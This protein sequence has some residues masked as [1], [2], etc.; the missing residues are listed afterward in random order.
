MWSGFS[1]ERH[2]LRFWRM[3]LHQSRY[4]I[5][6]NLQ[7]K[8]FIISELFVFNSAFIIGIGNWV[9]ACH[10]AKS[11]SWCQ[12]PREN[13]TSQ[14][15]C[16]WQPYLARQEGQNKEQLAKARRVG[17]SSPWEEIPGSYQWHRQGTI[18]MSLGIFRIYM[19]TKLQM[20]HYASWFIF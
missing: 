11:Y 17:Q 2:F 20:R 15:S 12:D 18:P 9:P 1:Q 8:N 5:C 10:A 19:N 4:F 14:T 7:L 13:E 16:G 3:L 6:K